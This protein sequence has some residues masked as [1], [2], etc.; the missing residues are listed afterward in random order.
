MKAFSISLTQ[1]FFWPDASTHF[2][3]PADSLDESN[4]QV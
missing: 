1:E 4:E 2:A 3:M